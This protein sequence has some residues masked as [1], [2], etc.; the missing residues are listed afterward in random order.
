MFLTTEAELPKRSV[1]LTKTRR[2]EIFTSCIK[3]RNPSTWAQCC[4]WRK[5]ITD[6][7]SR[8]GNWAN[9]MYIAVFF[10]P[11]TPCNLRKLYGVIK[12]FVDQRISHKISR[13]RRVSIRTLRD[14]HF[15]FK[16]RSRIKF[17]AESEEQM[18]IRTR[19]TTTWKLGDQEAHELLILSV[20]QRRYLRPKRRFKIT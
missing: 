1:P 8:P 3:P 14:Y 15:R 7:E 11:K 12:L 18:I 10:S 4:V 20:P 16:L 9:L 2:C 19:T 13:L 17:H 6:L 5:Y